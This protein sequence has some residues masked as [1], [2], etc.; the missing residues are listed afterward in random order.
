[1]E[2][3]GFILFR[4]RLG[5]WLAS[6]AFTGL[7][8]GPQAASAQSKPV[9]SRPV[10]QSLP[11]ADSRRLSAALARI[12]R[13]PRDYAALIDAGDAANAI[14]DAEAA[15]GFY[16]RADAINP[17]NPRIKAGL[18]RALVLQGKPT[19]AIPLFA[20]AEAGGAAVDV[21][22]DRGL[23]YDLVGDTATAQRYY[24]A[25]LAQ[26]N[27]DEARRRLGVSLAITG[28]AEASNAMLMPLL[29][30][31]DKPAWRAHAFALAIAGKTKEAVDTVNAILPP[32]LAQSVTPYLRYMPRLTRA[33]QAAA[34][35]LGKFPRASEI[36]RDDPVIAA[37]VP[38][39]ATRLAT[40]GGGLIPRGKPLGGGRSQVADQAAA[41]PAPLTNS[42]R[43]ARDRAARLAKAEADR[44]ARVA[45][46]EPRPAINRD[47]DGELPALASSAPMTP[48]VAMAP[49]PPQ[50]P[51]TPAPSPSPATVQNLPVRGSASS[52]LPPVETPRPALT[53]VRPAST[54]VVRTGSLALPGTTSVQPPASLAAAT[55]NPAP[56]PTP[57]PT[58][59]P[60]RSA[61]PGFDLAALPASAQRAGEAPVPS[62]AVAATPQAVSLEQA[63]A[64]LGAPSRAPAPIAG[65]VDVRGIE[66]AKPAPPVELAQQQ[67]AKAEVA[68]P[69]KVTAKKGAAARLVESVEPAPD[70]NATDKRG[71]LSAKDAK[72]ADAKLAA[73]KKA[74]A[75]KPPA[76]PSRIW[77][78]VGVGRDKAAIG[79]DWRKF[80]KQNPA[81]FKGREP[82]TSDMGR[83]NRILAGPF[84]TQKAASDLVTKL[85]KADVGGAFVWNSPAGQA[86]DPLAAK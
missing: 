55:A 50:T 11:S 29:R 68:T 10:V 56:S 75:K 86:V 39:V 70:K 72:L 54:A 66:P 9:V 45:P 71:R 4:R 26:R 81:L 82:Y 12:S 38:P 44:A 2:G 20:S 80:V 83:T 19:D 53:P 65:A 30:K 3:K 23:A 37:Y 16:K 59:S 61:T 32:A 69:S 5:A 1:M 33:Q 76:N 67:P 41:A 78:Q 47:S 17:S 60:V 15:A 58:P 79:Y 22:S 43:R 28:D 27:D 36:G 31:Q 13:D 62:P 24:Q 85:K 48:A 74:E 77:V 14:G 51:P 18:A 7:L 6:A 63:F 21:T 34:V 35:N 49:L 57:S 46:P 8:I 25:A 73:A 84:E 64:D 52:A 42:Q 40:V